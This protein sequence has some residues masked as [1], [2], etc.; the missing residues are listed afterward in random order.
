MS[1]CSCQGNRLSA[2]TR[3]EFL[4]VGASGVL[5]LT[6]AELL[7]W[8]QAQ[9]GGTVGPLGP[10]AKSVLHIFLPGGMAHQE[11]FDPKPY[12][13]LEYRGSF[14]IGQDQDPRRGVLRDLAED[15]QDRRQDHAWSAR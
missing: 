1:P 14:G 13:P 10:K 7:R 15:R 2:P 3:R 9:A 11:S 6:L 12:A 8:E 5:G 4:T